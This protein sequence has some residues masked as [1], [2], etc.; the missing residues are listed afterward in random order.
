MPRSGQHRPTAFTL[1]EVLVVVAIIGILTAILLPA[2][3]RARDVA[4]QAKCASILRQ[5]GIGFQMYADQYKGLIP[6]TGD[7]SCNPYG[8]WDSYFP[9]YPQDESGYTDVVAPLLGQPAWSSFADGQRPTTGVWQCPLAFPWPDSSYGYAPSVIG[10]HSYAANEYLDKD[11]NIGM[12]NA[13][14]PYASFLQLAKA[15][16][17]SVTLLMFE[18]TLNPTA[19]FGQQPNPSVSCLSGLE[20]HENA[21]SFSDRHPHVAGKLGGNRMMLDGHVEWAEHLWDPTLPDPTQPP[22]TNREWFP[23]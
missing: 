14:V 3:H 1:V 10:Y 23:Y 16:Q 18:T 20:S 6:H 12:G 15:R 4:Q 7:R 19:G 22:T 9:L 2:L 13:F 5:W 17:P 21:E 11:N 8:F